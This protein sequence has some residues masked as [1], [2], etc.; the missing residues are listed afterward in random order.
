[1]KK[2]LLTDVELRARWSRDRSSTYYVEEGAI[3]TP[4]AK[5]FLKEHNIQLCSCNQYSIH[6]FYHE[7][8]LS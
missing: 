8:P 5:D 3:L 6:L 7:K 1:M 2:Y 4:S